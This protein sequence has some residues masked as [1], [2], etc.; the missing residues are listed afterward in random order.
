MRRMLDLP[1]EGFDPEGV[2]FSHPVGC[3]WCRGLGYRGRVGVFEMLQVQRAAHDLVLERAS[4]KRIRE[5]AERDGMKTL[6]ES[7]WDLIVSGVSSPEEAIRHVRT[8]EEE[9]PA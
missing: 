9:G 3:E 6:Q 1:V 2:A 4:A 8:T 7:A 5:A